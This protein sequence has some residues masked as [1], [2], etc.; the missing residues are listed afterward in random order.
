MVE[1]YRNREIVKLKLRNWEMQSK[2]IY[3]EN[4]CL[5]PGTW[6]SKNNSHYS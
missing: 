1:K 6:E 5:K 3:K 2:N 4:K